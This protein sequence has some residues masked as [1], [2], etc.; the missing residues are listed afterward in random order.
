MLGNEQEQ[1]LTTNLVENTAKW[2]VI[3]SP[4]PLLP[5]R[6]RFDGKELRYI[7]A[8]DMYPANRARIASAIESAELGHPLILSGDVHSFWAVDGARTKDT[9]E[10]IPVVEFVSSSV[11][12]NWPEQL[13]RPI[14]ENLPHNPQVQFYNPNKR[15]YML[16]DVSK[17][18]W[19]TT[20]RAIDDVRDEASSATD[21]A[22]FIVRRGE[23]GFKR[24]D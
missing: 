11:T 19:K 24:V 6:Y 4:G 2:N 12:A 7:G 20:F 17:S 1:W 18:E 22:R 3:A 21:L 5:F 23:A 8:W 10:R 16:L 15:G 13:A 14:T 9:S